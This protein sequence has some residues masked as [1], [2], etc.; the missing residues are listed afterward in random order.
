MKYEIL[1]TFSVRAPFYSFASYKEYLTNVDTKKEILNWFEHDWFKEA[2]QVSS[3]SLYSSLVE[4]K[5]D[6]QKL[7]IGLQNYLSRMSTRTTPFGFLAGVGL[8]TFTE[9]EADENKIRYQKSIRP[10]TE[11]LFKVIKKIEDYNRG[12]LYLA[13]NAGTTVLAS[14]CL[15]EWN[16]CLMNEEREEKRIKLQSYINNTTAVKIVKEKS[17]NFICTKELVNILQKEY[18]KVKE[19][20]FVSFINELVN[21]EFLISDVRG[22]PLCH[23]KLGEMLKVI[24]ERNYGLPDELLLG[25]KQIEL[26]IYNYNRT[27]FGQG[28]ALYDV[29]ISNMKRIAESNNYIHAEM[30][31]KDKI[32]LTKDAKKDLMGFVDLLSTMA[33]E[34]LFQAMKVWEDRFIERYSYTEQLLLDVIDPIKGMGLPL[35]GKEVARGIDDFQKEL[36]FNIQKTFGD[37]E[38]TIELENFNSYSGKIGSTRAVDAQEL[39]LAFYIFKNIDQELQYIVSPVVGEKTVGSIVSRFMRNFEEQKE[40]INV[41]SDED[42]YDGVEIVFYPQVSRLSNIQGTTTKHKYALEFGS[43]TQLENLE[44]LKLSD[45]IINVL[46][47][48]IY[49]KHKNT[50]RRL[51]FFLTNALRSD[52]A[53]PVAQ[54]LENCRIYKRSNL[55]SIISKLSYISNSFAM[56]PRITY[57]NIIVKEKQW[58]LPS[59]KF[60]KLKEKEFIEEF[61]SF[62]ETFKM[63]RFIFLQEF[64][65][66]V[67]IDITNEDNQRFIYSSFRKNNTIT[68]LENLFSDA[69]MLVKN[70]KGESLISE[71]IFSFKSSNENFN[72]RIKKISFQPITKIPP[73]FIPLQQY[74]YLKIY[75]VEI[76][77]EEIITKYLV[78]FGEKSVIDG[79]IERFYYIRYHDGQSHL[80][81]RF[82]LLQDGESNNKCLTQLNG[83]LEEIKAIGYS[84]KIQYDT[85]IPEIKRYGGELIYDEIE[86]FFYL[87][88]KVTAELLNIYKLSHGKIEKTE[89]GIIAVCKLLLDTNMG[90]KQA[91][92][93]IEKNTIKNHFKKE[94]RQEKQRFMDL[95]LN[96]NRDY[97][98]E[99]NLILEQQSK[100]LQRIWAKINKHEKNLPTLKEDII[101]SLLHMFCI[102]FFG[103]DREK[104]VYVSNI[105][106]KTL[107][108]VYMFQKSIASGG[109]NQ[110]SKENGKYE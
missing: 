21:K 100:C 99:V 24:N 1:D 67:L 95:L 75:T 2:I 101:G 92:E 14:K 44:M 38:S 72:N 3:Y 104:E 22:T 82:K 7:R 17:E 32:C 19:E 54:F 109:R 31:T 94:F 73:L 5:G 106:S 64:D 48:G 66:R 52:F 87:N 56:V 74:I 90:W 103:V 98:R 96:K 62:A 84:S 86:H 108:A 45:I 71:Y 27:D 33:D 59:A 16:T 97:Y 41:V 63:D 35:M 4:K 79:F 65:K 34:N 18:P 80:R 91:I 46:P 6:P 107:Y 93:L 58:S 28:I 37:P 81:I 49:F 60:K 68:F 43:K 10:D 25:L 76:F 26:D 57:K 51:K 89:I 23:D 53:P 13:W 15:N 39:D 55:F 78:P 70:N 69:N 11:W 61:I 47:E 12:R 77:E 42:D 9:T 105:S 20:I 40:A 36:I 88:S 85:Y 30:F 8:G 29:I 102:R 50:N 83:V 110:E